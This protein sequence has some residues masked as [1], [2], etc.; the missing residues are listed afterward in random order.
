M[1][2]V[3]LDVQNNCYRK[4]PDGSYKHWGTAISK[5]AAID[6]VAHDIEREFLAVK[7][8]G[9]EIINVAA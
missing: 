8:I 2:L 1:R 9:P 3:H 4:A 5:D 6:W 7:L